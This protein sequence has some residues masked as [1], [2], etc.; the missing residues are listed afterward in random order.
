MFQYKVH[1]VLPN[2]E[3][4]DAIS[5]YALLLQQTL[6]RLGFQSNIYAQYIHPRLRRN[7]IPLASMS[8][9]AAD[10][11]IIWLFHYSIVSDITRQMR[12]MRGRV[13]LLYHN[14]TPPDLSI[15]GENFFSSKLYAGLQDLKSFVDIPVM[16]VGSSAYNMKQLESVGFKRTEILPIIL[17][18]SL[19][20][21]APDP[22]IMHRFNDGMVNFVTVSR[23][24]P[25]KKIEDILRVFYYYQN[26]INPNSRL[27][28]IGDSKGMEWY[29]DQ[30]INFHH[31]LNLQNVIFTGRVRFRELIAY[32]RLA[33]IYLCMSEHEGFGVPLLEC[34][35]L[36]IPIIAYNCSAVGETLDDAGVLVNEKKCGEIAELAHLILSDQDLR[37]RIINKQKDRALAFQPDSLISRLQKIL[38]LAAQ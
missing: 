34:M 28:I 11:K 31:K 2:M 3:Y 20:D 26:L 24:Y 33:R 23:I 38:A 10:E 7:T 18:Y 27:F 29:Y 15:G 37:T 17:N 32:Y 16:A 14:I 22:A 21:R 13:V 8:R 35:Y 9:C 6:R 25:H 1:Q 36:G 30:L 12:E 5:N 19:F 4:G